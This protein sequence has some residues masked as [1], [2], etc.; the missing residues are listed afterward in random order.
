MV[1]NLRLAAIVAL[2]FYLFVDPFERGFFCNDESLIH[3]YKEDTIS[4]LMLV[5]AG[6]VVSIS[7]V[8]SLK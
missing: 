7:L 6:M 4:T 5:I 1:N 8:S 2:L 3:P